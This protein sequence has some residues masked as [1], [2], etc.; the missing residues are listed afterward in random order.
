MKKLMLF[1]AFGCAALGFISCEQKSIDTTIHVT[2]VK[3]DKDT[4]VVE[5]GESFQL[6]ATVMPTN[7]TYKT[8]TWSSTSSG[9]ATVDSTGLVKTFGQGSCWI[10]AM[11]DNILGGTF[12][13]VEAPPVHYI[14]NGVDWG[15]ACTVIGHSGEDSY[16]PSASR[17]M[18]DISVIWA[19][20]N[21]G[22]TAANPAGLYYQ[23][24]RKTGLALNPA[25]A[26][27]WTGA[28]EEADPNIF[29]KKGSTKDWIS[30][31]DNGFWN[32]GTELSPKK[33]KYDPCPEGWR[34]PTARELFSINHASQVPA[35]VG[36]ID[37][38]WYLGS[39]ASLATKNKVFLPGTGMQKPDSGVL[40]R[41]KYCAYW[42]SCP[43][44]T[45]RA[46]YTHCN[47]AGGSSQAY[48]RDR[49]YGMKVRCVYIQDAN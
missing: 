18:D 19:P 23:W 13:T 24:G 42:S 20:V 17:T 3:V 26:N 15:A 8:I 45:D 47:P 12:V 7:A 40:E 48:Y 27:Q 39:A 38:A 1:A 5:A 2:D 25:T 11:A 22:T 43:Y 33:S 41:D 44:S 16:V 28:N 36:G 30:V 31:S 10:C 34:V 49:A 6:A 21:C 4:V 9:V 32:D 46:Y 29:Y 37:G 14:V 35:T